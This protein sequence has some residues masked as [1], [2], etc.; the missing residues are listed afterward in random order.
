M[1]KT[2]KENLDLYNKHTNPLKWIVKRLIEFDSSLLIENDFDENS[3]NNYNH[4]ISVDDLK[5][6]ITDY[7]EKEGLDITNENKGIS[8]NKLTNTIKSAFNLW[9][10]NDNYN[11]D[12]K[13]LRKR[14]K[15]N[16][17]YVYPNV[18]YKDK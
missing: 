14:E 6:S 15:G 17:Y 5:Q 1:K 18:K 4:Y 2:T 8:T 9:S 13:P 11:Y 12:Y 3:L 10:L 7:A 16:R